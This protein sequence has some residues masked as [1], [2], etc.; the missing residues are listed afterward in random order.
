MAQSVASKPVTPPELVDP[1]QGMDGAL[2]MSKPPD[3]TAFR[4]DYQFPDTVESATPPVL[5]TDAN[6]AYRTYVKPGM[7]RAYSVPRLTKSSFSSDQPAMIP[8]DAEST[9]FS[10]AGKLEKQQ[11]EHTGQKAFTLALAPPSEPMRSNQ[12]VS[13]RMA[14]VRPAGTSSRTKPSSSN[15]S[16]VPVADSEGVELVPPGFTEQMGS[17]RLDSTTNP[18]YDSI[19][20][21]VA[22]LERLT[23]TDTG[24]LRRYDPQKPSVRRRGVTELPSRANMP[25]R[26]LISSYSASNLSDQ[27]ASS[28]KFSADG[29]ASTMHN[30]PIFRR[31]AYNVLLQTQSHTNLSIGEDRIETVE[32]VRLGTGVSNQSL[33]PPIKS[34]GIIAS[35]PTSRRQSLQSVMANKGS[36]N[37]SKINLE[38]ASVLSSAVDERPRQWRYGTADR[39]KQSEFLRNKERARRV[40]QQARSIVKKSRGERDEDEDERGFEYEENLQPASDVPDGN[41]DLKSIHDR[42]RRIMEPDPPKLRRLSARLAVGS[43]GAQGV[44]IALSN[45]LNT[46]G[47]DPETLSAT[48]LFLNDFVVV[49]SK[50]NELLQNEISTQVHNI[51]FVPQN[52]IPRMGYEDAKYFF[53]NCFNYLKTLPDVLSPAAVEDLIEDIESAEDDQERIFLIQK[54]MARMGREEYV[55]LKA[56][57][58]HLFRISILMDRDVC[59]GLAFIMAPILFRRPKPAATPSSAVIMPSPAVL[60]MQ[61]SQGTFA[62]TPRSGTIAELPSNIDFP[63]QETADPAQQ[64]DFASS[65]SIMLAGQNT[66]L[67]HSQLSANLED[68]L[69]EEM[70]RTFLNKP[71]PGVRTEVA[72]ER[73]KDPV[74]MPPKYDVAPSSIASSAS[75]TEDYQSIHSD[76]Q[77][78]VTAYPVRPPMTPEPSAQSLRVTVPTENPL[79]PI[80][81]SPAGT[82]HS[83]QSVVSEMDRQRAPPA[84]AVRMKAQEDDVSSDD[85]FNTIIA[86]NI[87]LSAEASA[88][89]L[90]IQEFERIFMW[91]T[92]AHTRR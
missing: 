33:L 3:Q 48:R 45:A 13:P 65:V 26:P 47:Q 36:K 84:T 38:T 35:Q 59:Q 90:L 81:G 15:P 67:R 50:I 64:K 40:A 16:A 46:T 76:L 72:L 70:L 56:A 25:P 71:I 91:N 60:R 78:T 14:R 58:G 54:C 29:T 30:R 42:M 5:K 17:A 89:A 86:T 34:G 75:R 7:R 31:S 24:Q 55:I 85:L 69:G 12:R 18:A 1:S 92:F 53:F 19:N 43:K 41:V 87:V 37:G 4:Q 49:E 63:V 20:D 80:Q 88:L 73:I 27:S 23:N 83:A 21:L 10:H 6:R 66:G 62:R 82:P 2:E 68:S 57:V 39:V 77:R 9:V 8:P 52:H 51:D 11:S 61:A 28:A 79:T 22:A 32:E 74:L 44:Y